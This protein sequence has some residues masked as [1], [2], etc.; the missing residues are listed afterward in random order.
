MYKSPKLTSIQSPK[1]VK[2]EELM[3]G[4]NL[5]SSDVKKDENSEY[6]CVV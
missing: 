6:Q 3:K 5:A 2:K 4:I 1:K